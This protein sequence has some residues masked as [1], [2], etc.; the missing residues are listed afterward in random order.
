MAKIY[1]NINTMKEKLIKF[2]R[3]G[4]QEIELVIF[5]KFGI[6]VYV[7]GGKDKVDVPSLFSGE[8]DC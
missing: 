7:V 4:G 1:L 5:N 6:F 3:V 2:L 8:R